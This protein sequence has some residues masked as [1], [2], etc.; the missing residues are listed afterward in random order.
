MA[1]SIRSESEIL[2]A[3]PEIPRACLQI[4]N[5]SLSV[6]V[7]NR[8]KTKIEDIVLEYFSHQDDFWSDPIKVTSL[9]KPGEV[10]HHDLSSK[11]ILMR[12]Y[13]LKW[14]VDGN[15]FLSEITHPPELQFYQCIGLWYF[16][17]AGDYAIWEVTRSLP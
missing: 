4:S 11:K 2:T 3:L 5:H 6:T 16:S 1:L 17:D 13:K 14:L 7:E 12:K 8:S 10:K 9:V 15:A